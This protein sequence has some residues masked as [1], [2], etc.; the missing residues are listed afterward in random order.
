MTPHPVKVIIDADCYRHL[1]VGVNYDLPE[2]VPR[3]EQV[4]GAIVVLEISMSR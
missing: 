1:T 2:K 3:K 4:H